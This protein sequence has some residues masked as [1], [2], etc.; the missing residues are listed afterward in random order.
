MR[1]RD[2]KDMRQRDKKESKDKNLVYHNPMLLVSKRK[3]KTKYLEY[4]FGD[5]KKKQP[6]CFVT[7]ETVIPE[8]PTDIIEKPNTE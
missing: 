8:M 1:Q 7:L 6:S 4:Q 5:W 3:F 2:K